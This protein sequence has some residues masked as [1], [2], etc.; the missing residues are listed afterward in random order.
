M[1][2][3]AAIDLHSN[4]S[5]PV[6][7]DEDGKV[8][9]TK[10]VPN[11]PASAI[12]DALAPYRDDIVA[13]AVE[14]TPNWYWLERT[15]REARFK[16]EL[17]NTTGVDQ[18]GGLKYGNDFSDAKNLADLMRMGRLPTAYICPEKDRALRDLA[19]RRGHLV[20]QRTAELLIAHNL[21]ARDLGDHVTGNALKSLLAS[22]IDKMALLPNQKTSLKA[23]VAVIR[24]L[25]NQIFR[26]ERDILKQVR[27]LAAFHRLKSVSGVGD[28]LALTIAVE[29]GDIARF[30]NAGNFASYARMVKSERISNGKKKGEGNTKCGNRYLAWAFIEAAHHAIAND[31]VIKAWYQRKC[32]K[33][34]KV[35]AIKA[36]AHKLARASFHIMINGTEFDARRAFS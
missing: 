12:V 34:H 22:T 25:Q 4:N 5:V 19:R 13:V 33:S 30:R 20:N 35:V 16:V 14:S 6:V 24:C 17:V 31:P 2:L 7:M 1:Q 29:V 26:I 8:V 28:I 9:F 11:R 27:P 21:I 32:T 15:L 18:Y 3:Y 10:R 36:V 23:T